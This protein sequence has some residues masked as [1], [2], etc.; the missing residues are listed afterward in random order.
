LGTVVSD[1]AVAEFEDLHGSA[2]QDA[3]A[4]DEPIYHQMGPRVKPTSGP[5]AR[6]QSPIDGGG[7]ASPAGRAVGTFRQ[8]GRSR[9]RDI[10]GRLDS[11]LSRGQ[12]RSTSSDS[13]RPQKGASDKCRTR[14]TLSNGSLKRYA[15]TEDG[16]RS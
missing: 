2:T 12:N 8:V 3:L 14:H 4:M 7:S 15:L 5:L 9:P 13:P 1:E 6:P 16:R 11:H 10:R